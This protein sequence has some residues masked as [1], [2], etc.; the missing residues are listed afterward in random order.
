MPTTFGGRD[1]Y[2]DQLGVQLSSSDPKMLIYPP[3]IADMASA[4]AEKQGC[5]GFDWDSFATR[6]AP[7][8]EF[9]ETSPEDICY[10][11]YSSGSTRFPQ[12]VAVTLQ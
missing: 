10:L 2:I 5:M 3:E 12:G 1:S 4:A 11:Q 6:E 9:P 8:C 7:E